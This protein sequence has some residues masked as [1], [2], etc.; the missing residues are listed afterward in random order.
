MTF[1][2]GKIW[3]HPLQMQQKLKDVVK[4]RVPSF[5]LPLL[6]LPNTSQQAVHPLWKVWKT[7][8]EV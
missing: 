5:I 6:S 4:T 8:L 7:Q 3:A 1:G 2:P